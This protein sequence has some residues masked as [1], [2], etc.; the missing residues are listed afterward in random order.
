[1][2]LS[3]LAAKKAE[4]EEEV[5]AIEKPSFL[6][7]LSLRER[8]RNHHGS[9]TEVSIP[10]QRRSAPESFLFPGSYTIPLSFAVTNKPPVVG[11]SDPD[12]VCF[13]KDIK[14]TKEQARELP[15]LPWEARCREFGEKELPKLPWEG[16]GRELSRELPEI[17]WEARS[18]EIS[19]ELPELPWEARNQ[20]IREKEEKVKE[21][22]EEIEEPVW[23]KRVEK[24]VPPP[25]SIENR[26]KA[27][28][29]E[30]ISFKSACLL[31]ILHLL[32]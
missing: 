9:H 20:E 25:H 7:T 23:V 12:E 8:R 28:T 2:E 18:R 29:Y 1:M 3:L 15:E 16:K 22:V 11:G 4:D 17:P 31:N 24:P 10:E 6:E 14:E 26:P 13:T 21:K 5:P 30:T 19:K 32:I 27:K